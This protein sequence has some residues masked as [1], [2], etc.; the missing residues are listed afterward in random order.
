MPGR[1]GAAHR[2]ETDFGCGLFPRQGQRVR[3]T[4]VT[5]KIVW[6]KSKILQVSAHHQIHLDFESDDR[7]GSAVSDL[8]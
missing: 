4:F 7:F 8:V 1:E 5:V 6:A 3:C 2:V